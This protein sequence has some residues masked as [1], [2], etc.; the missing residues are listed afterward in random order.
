MNMQVRGGAYIGMPSRRLSV[1]SGQRLWNV[2]EMLSFVADALGCW[3]WGSLP[4]MPR[5]CVPLA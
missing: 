3:W 5:Y 2:V 1:I 4:G